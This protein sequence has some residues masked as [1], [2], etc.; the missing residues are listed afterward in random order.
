MDPIYREML[1]LLFRW[2]HLIAGIMWVGNSMLFNW[3]DRNLTHPPG[4]S[5]NL[6]G[7]LWMVHSGGFYQVEKMQLEPHQMPPVLHWFKWQS[8]IT[9]ISGI[10]LLGI[11]YYMG[12]G[13]LLVDPRV[14]TLDPGTATA[15]CIGLLVVAWFV[16]DLLWTSPLGKQGKVATAI[17]LALV[18]AVTYG[19]CHLLSGR[20]AYLHV[21]AMLGT[22]MATNVFRYIIPSQRT[23]VAATQNGQ[24]QDA[25]I[26]YRAKQRSI[27]NNYM[28]FPVLIIMI[29]NH[30]PSTYGHEL[31][32]LILLVLIAAGAGVRHFMNIRFTYAGWRPAL[33]A[34]VV[35]GL[36]GLLFLVTRPPAGAPAVTASPGGTPVSLAQVQPVIAQRC[37]TCHAARPT[38]AMFAA[39]PA[40]VVFDTPLQIQ[41]LA[42]RIKARAVSTE[43]MPLANKTGMTAAERALLGR[44]IAEGAKIQP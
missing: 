39:P 14:A 22:L 12:G 20:A 5:A 43:T 32:W 37:A 4:A 26:A 7:E 15:I 10:C 30:Y 38:D 27:H 18:V 24:P 28:T 23:L 44:W 9:W 31:N 16:Y 36:A 25:A 33:V 42:E 21:G 1:D 13:G 41:Q 2:V 35:A 8:Y 6:E 11:V 40:G 3:L 34:T 19:L 29:S 17:S